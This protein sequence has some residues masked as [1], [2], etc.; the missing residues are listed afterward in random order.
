MLKEKLLVGVPV[1]V[2]KQMN[3]N[4]LVDGEPWTKWA[5]YLRSLRET[6]G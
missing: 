5:Q 3:D 6:P 2:R 1:P 4:P